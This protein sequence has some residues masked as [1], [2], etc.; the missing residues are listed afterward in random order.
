M[1]YH[2][3]IAFLNGPGDEA[4]IHVH[5]SSEGTYIIYLKP[6]CRCLALRERIHMSSH[7]G[8][9]IVDV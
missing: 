8:Y 9:V 6:R 4:S 7:V 5:E 3:V 1:P 2:I